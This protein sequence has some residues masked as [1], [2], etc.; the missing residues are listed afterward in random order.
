MYKKGGCTNFMSNLMN[1]KMQTILYIIII[2][3][4]TS[5]LY[6]SLYIYLNYLFSGV[7]FMCLLSLLQGSSNRFRGVVSLVLWSGDCSCMKMHPKL[8]SIEPVKQHY[9]RCSMYGVFIYVYYNCNPNVG[10]YTIHW[11]FGYYF[12]LYWLFNLDP[13]SLYSNGL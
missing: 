1:I 11:V 7:F 9:P 6:T 12:P 10:K 2:I 4:K 3:H 5:S 8:S 13:G